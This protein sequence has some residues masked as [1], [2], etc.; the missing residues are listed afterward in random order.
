MPAPTGVLPGGADPA[1]GLWPAVRAGYKWGH[2][3]GLRSAAAKQEP[4][5]IHKHRAAVGI[6]VSFGLG[7]S[8][9]LTFMPGRSD[10]G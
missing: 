3:A 6:L 1:L 7:L 9:W 5:V 8:A 2:A 10:A 4:N